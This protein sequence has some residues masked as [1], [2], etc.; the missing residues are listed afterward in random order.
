MKLS[1]IY[2]GGRMGAYMYIGPCLIEDIDV[3][4]ILREKLVK[5]LARNEI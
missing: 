5:H 3:T 2:M 4:F 1:H